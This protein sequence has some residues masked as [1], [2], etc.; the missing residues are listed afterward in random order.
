MAF[1]YDNIL[2][3][4]GKRAIAQTEV[5]NYMLDNLKP[6]F[7]RRPYQIE[8]FQR[9]TSTYSIIENS[10]EGFNVDVIS[11]YC[12]NNN[13]Y[14]YSYFI[15]NKKLFLTL[16]LEDRSSGCDEICAERY[17]KIDEY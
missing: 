4:F 15:E 8:A 14:E 10:K 12:N 6:G 5:P 13:S 17:L 1:L 2:Q 9:Y 7:G 16:L 3:E 11:L